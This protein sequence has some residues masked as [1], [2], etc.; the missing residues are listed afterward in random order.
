MNGE[1][2]SFFARIGRGKIT[3]KKAGPLYRVESYDMKGVITRW[4]EAVN[5][6]INEYKGEPPVQDKREYSVN[7]E[8][9]FFM[10]GDGRGMILGPMRRDI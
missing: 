9:F 8:V 10:F 4:I 5:A 7:D 2:S 1:Y 3:D 6:G